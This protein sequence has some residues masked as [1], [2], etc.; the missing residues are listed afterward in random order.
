ME[1]LITFL[2][3]MKRDALR[4]IVNSDSKA[5]FKDLSFGV[6]L[7]ESKVNNLPGLLRDSVF[8]RHIFPVKEK[9]GLSGDRRVDLKALLS[10]LVVNKS[11]N[12]VRFNVQCR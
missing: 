9:V 5:V 6:C 3:L 10:S 2:P 11:Y 4:E 12:G 1:Y 7:V 8:V